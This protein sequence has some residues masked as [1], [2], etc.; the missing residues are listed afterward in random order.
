MQIQ[1]EKGYRRLKETE[2]RALYAAARHNGVELSSIISEQ[3][4]VRLG[5]IV[6]E[7]MFSSSALA[8]PSQL[9]FLFRPYVECE[10][11]AC[12]SRY[13]NKSNHQ[14]NYDWGG[15]N[16]PHLQRFADPH[17]DVKLKSNK[18][19]SHAACT[20]ALSSC[21]LSAHNNLYIMIELIL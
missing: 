14:N 12:I 4:L 1:G 11:G 16:I 7:S 13:N 20:V 9:P 17:N 2:G 19:K 15:N 3:E 6:G 18:K 5:S 21:M 10:A 8:S